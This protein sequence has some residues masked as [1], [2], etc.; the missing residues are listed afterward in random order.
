[1]RT[2][3]PHL[4]PTC[5]VFAVMA[6][7]SLAWAN[8]APMVGNVTASQRTD[9]SKK[10]DIRYDLG[11]ADNDA[12]TVSML[13][14]N[15]GGVTWTVPATTF[16]AGSAV[17]SGITPET[18][19]L[20]VWD[21]KVDLPGVFGS[22][23]TVRVCADDGHNS[24]PPGM[25]LIPA[26]E[27]LMGNS[28]SSSEGLSNELPRHAVYVDA[29]S[30]DTT[31][32]T[33]DQY[34]DALNW[35]YG[36]GGLITV[37]SGV[38]YMY[39]SGTSYPYSDT[40]SSTSD[41]RIT[42]NGTSFGVVSG[43][44]D[45]PMVR[46][47]W[48]GSVAYANWRSGMQGKPLCYD[49]S[50][51]NCNFGGGYRLPT[52]AEW[53]KAAR[54]GS[55]GHRFTWSD[56]DYIQHARAT[57]RSLSDYSYD[58]SS[59][60]GD[61]PLWGGGGWPYT[62]PV[63]FFNGSLRYKTDVGW[64]GTPTT[65]QTSNGAN[66]Y[67]LYDMAGNVWEWCNDWYRVYSAGSQ[68]NPRGPE[69]GSYRVLRGGGWNG[70]AYYCRVAHRLYGGPSYRFFYYGFRLALDARADS[71]CG[72]SVVFAVDNRYASGDFNQ[73]DH[74]DADDLETF[75][76]CA[77][78]PG[79]PYNAATLP[80]LSPGCTLTPDGNGRIAA[81]ANQDGDVDA[82]DF[83]VFQRCWSGSLPADPNCAN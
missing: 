74:V 37:T 64:P 70:S 10:V 27:F 60:R 19:K 73:D 56:S 63:G 71:G 5:T 30:M 46:V 58:N 53:E 67:G 36:Q 31:E 77:T 81:D 44:G 11:D 35:A 43:K 62:S 68:S 12:C 3:R 21:C 40:T 39:N 42:W 16:L 75:E 59:T 23:F 47:S 26:G 45:H 29:F 50:T 28:F 65:Y 72:E 51:W 6:W 9:G 34:K 76:A 2:V 1:M 7:A 8:S 4:S 33:N 17:G 41:S 69:S 55:S 61:H 82:D 49:L 57:Y 14:S 48:Y 38:V 54:G 22:Q 18:G 66:N 20:I 15:D 83:G 25:A 80:A 32:V 79:I 13:A 24:A 78:G 52:E